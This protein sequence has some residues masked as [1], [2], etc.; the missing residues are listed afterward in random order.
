MTD[1]Q[2]FNASAQIYQNMCSSLLERKGSIIEEKKGAAEE[3]VRAEMKNFDPVFGN[4]TLQMFL[5]GNRP[6]RPRSPYPR[7]RNSPRQK[8]S[9]RGLLATLTDV[10]LEVDK[11]YEDVPEDEIVRKIRERLEK[12]LS[13]NM[14]EIFQAI[15][16]HV[17]YLP[18]C[19][20]QDAQSADQNRDASALIQICRP[21]LS[22]DVRLG[23]SRS[24]IP[25]TRTQPQGPI[26]QW[27]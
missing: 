15:Q 16:K 2:V 6:R 24:F 10:Y 17:S 1:H 9:R 19:R 14:T 26:C 25:T 7:R 5:S 4:K 3:Y 8:I 23:P 11:E 12:P 21:S 27:T 13:Y 22:L 18:S 20:I